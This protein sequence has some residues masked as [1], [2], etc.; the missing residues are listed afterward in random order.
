MNVK[1]IVGAILLAFGA[2]GCLVAPFQPPAALVASYSAPLSTEGGFKQGEKIGKSE[3]INVLG[4]VA[5][6]DCSLNT[7][8]KDGHLKSVYYVDYEYFNVL[9]IYQRV[10]I[11]AV[12]D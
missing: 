12:G 10:T 11:N 9:G 1:V 5:V 7:A 6:G 4:L 3:A 2:S 8:I